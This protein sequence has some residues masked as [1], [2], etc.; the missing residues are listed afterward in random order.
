MYG[1]SSI[2]IGRVLP[3]YNSSTP[4]YLNN[5]SEH[6][7]QIF[8]KKIMEVKFQFWFENWTKETPVDLNL[9]FALKKTPGPKITKA[10]TILYTKAPFI[11]QIKQAQK[12]F[13]T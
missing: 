3:T 2:S 8:I 9:I 4:P 11:P 12:H 1:I 6:L 7:I 10:P 5:L 13:T